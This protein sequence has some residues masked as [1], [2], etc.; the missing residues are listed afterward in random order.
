MSDAMDHEAGVRQIEH[1]I[2]G[3][4]GLLREQPNAKASAHR[5]C[6]RHAVSPNCSFKFGVAPPKLRSQRR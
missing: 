2:A 6:R 5:Y 3:L 1:D 4:A